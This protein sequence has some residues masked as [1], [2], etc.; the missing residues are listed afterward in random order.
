[1][2][3]AARQ[4][5]AIDADGMFSPNASWAN[6]MEHLTLCSLEKPCLFN[7]GTGKD[8]AEHHDVAADNPEVVAR[9]LERFHTYDHEYHPDSI[10]LPEQMEARCN[11]VLNSGGWTSPWLHLNGSGTE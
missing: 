5:A 11:A 1:M 10:P 6:W 8:E 9:L 4:C 3:L 7:V 2:I